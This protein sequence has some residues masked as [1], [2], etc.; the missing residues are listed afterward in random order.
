MSVDAGPGVNGAAAELASS[1]IEAALNDSHA[2]ALV[3]GS[4]LRA[5]ITQEARKAMLGCSEAD[6]ATNL[7]DVLN[8]DRLITAKL[9][10]SGTSALLTLTLLDLSDA[11]RLGAVNKTV[12]LTDTIEPLLNQIPA[13]VWSLLGQDKVLGPLP[14]LA[15]NQ[16]PKNLIRPTRF[17]SLN[18]LRADP[19]NGFALLFFPGTQGHRFSP[20]LNLHGQGG[21]VGMGL[22]L[23]WHA[24]KKAES[25]TTLRLEM[26]IM[27]LKWRFLA[28]F[29]GISGGAVFFGQKTVDHPVQTR[30]DRFDGSS[31][32][33]VCGGTPSDPGFVACT[34]GLFR[35]AVGPRLGLQLAYGH[36]TLLL[37]AGYDFEL[38]V[39]REFDP[40]ITDPAKEMPIEQQP[41]LL[42]GMVWQLGL[43]LRL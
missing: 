18:E 4:Q 24:P 31:T 26:K 13:M 19:R 37:Q 1:W 42:E 3:T 40:S 33:Y 10:R 43:G 5:L 28:P 21:A 15:A 2:Y 27:P 20:F 32:N 8:T 7:K 23:G 16:S 41:P 17:P 29:L 11:Q 25:A 14:P 38:H 12:Q 39:L 9:L 35:A 22:E 36:L 34:R 30:Q 6:C